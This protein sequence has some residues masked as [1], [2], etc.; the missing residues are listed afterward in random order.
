[1]NIY[2]KAQSKTALTAKSKCCDEQIIL[3]GGLGLK[4]ICDKCRLIIHELDYL[5]SAEIMM[6][7]R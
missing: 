1:M 7:L 4:L 5:A 6:K 3:V 2:I